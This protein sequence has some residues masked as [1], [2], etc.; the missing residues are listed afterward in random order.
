MPQQQQSR[1]WATS[2]T[3]A[4]AH[5]N[6]RFLTHWVRPG[7]EPASSWLLL[8]FLTSWT[9]IGTPWKPFSG[10]FIQVIDDSMTIR[11]GYLINPGRTCEKPPLGHLHKVYI[12]RE[13]LVITALL[14]LLTQLSFHLFLLLRQFSWNDKTEIKQELENFAFLSHPL[15]FC[16]QPQTS[17]LTFLNLTN[18]TSLILTLVAWTFEFVSCLPNSRFSFS[19]YLVLKWSFN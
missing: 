6:A 18:V 1:V 17:V 3:Y 12:K 10:D 2:A 13:D 7:I 16:H 4:S 14:G 9:T 8:V 5:S 11:T 15:I 19:F